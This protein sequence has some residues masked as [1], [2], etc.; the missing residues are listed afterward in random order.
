[1][2]TGLA[3]V[4]YTFVL[5][6]VVLNCAAANK[7]GGGTGSRF[8]GLAIGFVMAAGGYGAE[9]SLVAASN[10]RWRSALTYPALSTAPSG[11]PSY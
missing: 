4:L 10:R 6:C 11:G 9:R 1:M 8:Y 7:N 3:E 2:E 5:S